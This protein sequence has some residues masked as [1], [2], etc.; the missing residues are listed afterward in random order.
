ME[1]PLASETKCERQN[2]TGE[3]DGYSTQGTS[4][5][6][7]GKE[8]ILCMLQG[9]ETHLNRIDHLRQQEDYRSRTEVK[10]IKGFKSHFREFIQY[11]W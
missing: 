8:E 6:K 3:E 1:I 4:M 2:R 9:H 7:K 5:R 10:I 11:R